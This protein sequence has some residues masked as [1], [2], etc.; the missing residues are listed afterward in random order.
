MMAH[1]CE[2]IIMNSLLPD[3]DP[4]EVLVIDFQFDHELD[5][6][7]TLQS[8]IV[9]I[10]TYVGSDPNPSA[11]LVNALVMDTTSVHQS[12]GGGVNGTVYKLKC[13]AVTSGGKTLIRK[14]LLPTVS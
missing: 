2:E 6:L 13:L 10:Y 11:M 12:V 3:K 1:P 7:E 8:A 14:C 5:P 9:T 4:E